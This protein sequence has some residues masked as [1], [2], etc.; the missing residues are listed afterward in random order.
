MVRWTRTRTPARDWRCC[1]YCCFPSYS[2]SSCAL[3]C[4]TLLA[5]AGAAAVLGAAIALMGTS[6][7]EQK[8][9]EVEESDCPAVFSTG[10]ADAGTTD[11]P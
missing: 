4:G 9:K 8:E 10:R 3:R 5:A 6:G 2:G 7:E 1:G 11:G